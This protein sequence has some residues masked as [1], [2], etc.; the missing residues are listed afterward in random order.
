MERNGSD[1]S[2]SSA[3]RKKAY[4]APQ[5]V[6]YGD[7]RRITQTGGINGTIDYYSDQIDDPNEYSPAAMGTM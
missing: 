4:V 2:D 5:L 1:C 3:A 7:V 6:V